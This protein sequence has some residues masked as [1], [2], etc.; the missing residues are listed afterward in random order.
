MPLDPEARAMLEQSGT[1][2][3]LKNMTVEEARKMRE[4][5]I[6]NPNPEK[7]GAV[8]NRLIHSPSG[9]IRLCIYT[10]EEPGLLPVFVYF[11]G[12]GFVFGPLNTHDQLCRALTNK[13]RCIVVSVDYRLSPEHKFPCALN[14]AYTSLC[15][16]ARNALSLR[17]DP[18]RI[19]VG[20]DSSGGNLAA[21][22][23]LLAREKE[24]PALRMQLLIYP[25]LHYSFDTKS[26]R[27]NATGYFLTRDVMELFWRYYL[28]NEEAGLHPHAS[29]LLEPDLSRLPAAV[30]ITA[31][32]DP[33]R[34]E[35]EAYVKR[36]EEAGVH[37]ELYR[38]EGM[39]HGFMNRIPL[40]QKGR[41]AIDKAASRLAA[42]FADK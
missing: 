20:G 12:G 17:G 18:E 42:F 22:V 39:I 19:A 33:L 37:A 1:E 30:V 31:E 38:Y 3:P 6:E 36:L 40:P 32:Y 16:V 9:D 15:W 35:G 5:M 2:L 26:Y 29:P 8:E 11:H 41:E 27:E 23:S 7:V 10:P 34:D 14:D 25:S 4:G 28:P 13:G 21:A 24:F